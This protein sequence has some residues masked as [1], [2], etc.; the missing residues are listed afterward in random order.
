M[1]RTALL[2]EV[3]FLSERN[4]QLEEDLH[5]VDGLRAQLV[6]VGRQKDILLVLLGNRVMRCWC[7]SNSLTR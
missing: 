7:L 4:A 5:D 2:E 6:E 3:S 1:S